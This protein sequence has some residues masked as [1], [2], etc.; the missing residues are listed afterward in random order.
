M[1]IVDRAT[2]IELHGDQIKNNETAAA[3]LGACTSQKSLHRFDTQV[4]FI[5][6]LP[7]RALKLE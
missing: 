1:W 7:L 4:K 5:I 6:A 3:A 2:G